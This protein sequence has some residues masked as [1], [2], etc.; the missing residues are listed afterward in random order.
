MPHDVEFGAGVASS[1]TTSGGVGSVAVV[2]EG[3]HCSVFDVRAA[4]SSACVARIACTG[5]QFAVAHDAL[6]GAL[7]VGGAD[8]VVAVVDVRRVRATRGARHRCAAHAFAAE[9][10]FRC[11]QMSVRSKWN[12]PTKLDIT[13]IRALG[14]ED[15]C[16]VAGADGEVACGRCQHGGDD[17]APTLQSDAALLGLAYASDV[18][19]LVALSERSTLYAA[20]RVVQSVDGAA[21]QQTHKRGR[22]F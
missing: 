21:P 19:V 17:G 13:S 9:R 5:A 2:A 22:K 18:N 15:F 14:V 6:N 20:H 4:P 16:L 8:R 3:A 11:A 12:A 7:L 10:N 1:T